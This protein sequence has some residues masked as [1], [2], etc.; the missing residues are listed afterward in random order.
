MTK[1]I[2]LPILCTLS[3]LL[4]LMAC[5]EEK[6]PLNYSPN[7][8]TGTATDIG[9]TSAT[10]SGSIRQNAGTLIA[11]G[12]ILLSERSNMEAYTKL[13]VTASAF[14][15]F[16]IEADNLTPGTVYYYCAYA[17]SGYSMVRGEIRSFT[18]QEGVAPV[19]GN[20]EITEHDEKSATLTAVI[21]D[22]GGSELVL[23]GAR[24]WEAAN[25]EEQ[26]E[27][28]GTLVTATPGTDF[29]VTIPNLL[30]ST[31]YIVCPVAQNATGVGYGPKLH[32]TT[33]EAVLPVLSAISPID[34][35]VVSIEVSAQVLDAGKSALKEVGF[36]W[37]MESREPTPSHNHQ[38]LPLPA[39][40][41]AFSFNIENLTAD[42]T[43]YIRA[44]A[45]NDEDEP[46]YS[47]VK[48]FRTTSSA[49]SV[50]RAT[51]EDI[52]YT[53]A[54]LKA[55]I[56][57]HG[58]LPI[59]AKGF[60][61]SDTNENPGEGDQRIIATN[62]DTDSI[63]VSVEGLASH[64]T[65]HVRAFATNA[66]G[67]SVSEEVYTFTT[68]DNRTVPTVETHEATNIGSMTATFSG[69]IAADG[70]TPITARGFC[71]G[72]DANP[73]QNGTRMAVD[74]N[75][76]D[77]T[78][79]ISGLASST[80][81]YVC[82]YAENEMG[83]AYGEVVSFTT[84]DRVPGIYSLEELL[85][86]REAVAN[87]EDTSPYVNADG[88]T[89][90]YADIDM[91]SVTD[92]TP[93]HGWGNTF[94][95]NGHTISNVHFTHTMSDGNRTFAFFTTLQDNMVCNLTIT[96]SYTVNNPE[97]LDNCFVGT[98]THENQ[99]TIRN[100]HSY[101]EINASGCDAGG[102]ACRNFGLI[103]DCT[104]HGSLIGGRAGGIFCAGWSDTRLSS[105]TRDCTNYGR[106]EAQRNVHGDY[107]GGI[108][109]DVTN[110]AT[111]TNC[112][113]EGVVISVG[114]AGGIIGYCA[115][116]IT[117]TNSENRAAVIGTRYVGGIIG[118]LICDSTTT[119]ILTDNT[120]TGTVNGEPA[121][122]DNA[123]GYDG[124]NQQ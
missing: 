25:G 4:T 37:S 6:D 120:N 15:S 8:A 74:G 10:L 111:L 104:N 78:L 24:Y 66:R 88:V 17:S 51:A 87:G 58:G 115:N 41:E 89:N 86:F 3:C 94:D 90:L 114:D 14:S 12:G 108:A 99:G 60:Y 93:M 92:W 100:C 85:A 29:T 34:S 35:T 69:R 117:L 119:I 61:Y 73:A 13:E 20:A 2:I 67:T 95:G 46:G 1:R 107:A 56:A 18:T 42:Q 98:F 80:T 59:T 118:R 30:P 122:E 81:Y 33:D 71:Y 121:S 40:G 9:Y 112:I 103:E 124:R 16:T 7:V 64:T 36:C 28:E 82:A 109:A 84:E 116:G 44:Y 52:E 70:N 45:Y 11:D 19:F 21:A 72:T 102:I 50:E 39:D 101:V 68:A 53:T 49:P 55:R 91:S 27:T 54:T 32:V 106:I 113:N 47:A 31:E 63:I 79:D 110:G 38:S 97:N 83:A 22:T 62:A 75:A 105:E 123:I 77:F 5:L 48:V 43:Y 26:V 23:C 96:G 57:S 65:Y 76:T